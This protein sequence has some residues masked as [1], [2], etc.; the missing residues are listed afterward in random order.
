MD[1]ILLQ[2]GLKCFS[3][4]MTFDLFDELLNSE[5]FCFFHNCMWQ[6]WYSE[7]NRVPPAG[8]VL[9]HPRVSPF[10]FDLLLQYFRHR[11]ATLDGFWS[12]HG[13]S[14]SCWV[15]YVLVTKQDIFLDLLGGFLSTHG[16][17]CSCPLS[18]GLPVLI[19]SASTCSSASLSLST[20]STDTGTRLSTSLSV[21]TLVLSQPNKTSMSI[22]LS[23]QT[24]WLLTLH[25]SSRAW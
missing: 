1:V 9:V 6:S 2:V 8:W 21:L 17:P 12:I 11:H 4:R 22:S 3:M 25:K 16:S 20:R 5:I 15:L 13:S 23:K 19:W 24:R 14:R 18:T 10:L 7:V